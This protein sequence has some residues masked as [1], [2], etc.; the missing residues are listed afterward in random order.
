[1]L[2]NQDPILGEEESKESRDNLKELW[3]LFLAAET[4]E[5]LEWLAA[6]HPIMEKAINKLVE[7]SSDEKLL[8]EIDLR[9]KA[10]MEEA[11]L[12]LFV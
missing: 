8:H 5:E 3:M 11:R 12:N 9:E 2:E 1:M 7:I 4:E 10:K 6:Q